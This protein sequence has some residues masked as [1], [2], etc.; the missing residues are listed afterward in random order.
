MHSS[1]SFL[2]RDSTTVKPK[3][4]FCYAYL[5]PAGTVPRGTSTRYYTRSQTMTPTMQPP[6][7]L[8]RKGDVSIST[9]CRRRYEQVEAAR[10]VRR[11][12]TYVNPAQP[13][14]GRFG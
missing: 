4:Q 1:R 12:V 7:L 8:V 2:A 11:R 9:T 5:V 14:L 13:L 3:E 6:T 10:S